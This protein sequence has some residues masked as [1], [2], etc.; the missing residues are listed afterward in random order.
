VVKKFLTDLADSAD[1]FTMLQIILILFLIE[2]NKRKFVLIR[3]IRGK[4]NFKII[5]ISGKRK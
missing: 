5:V 4:K 3:E 2:S 1:F